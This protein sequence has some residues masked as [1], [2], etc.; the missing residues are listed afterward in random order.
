MS[1]PLDSNAFQQSPGV[2]F[3]KEHHDEALELANRQ[4]SEADKK[5]TSEPAQPSLGSP[6][7]P[8]T[9]KLPRQ[10]VRLGVRLRDHLEQLVVRREVLLDHASLHAREIVRDGRERAKTWLS[11]SGVRSRESMPTS[12]ADL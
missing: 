2:L 3:C 4:A 6:P 10:I 5:P 9:V 7:P 11:C 1:S 12:L 8:S